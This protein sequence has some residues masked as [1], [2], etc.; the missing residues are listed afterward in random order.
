MFLLLC[1]LFASHQA[2]APRGEGDQ[3][4]AAPPAH[5]P[6]LLR[7]QGAHRLADRTQRGLRTRHGHQD[8]AETPRPEHHSSR[9]DTAVCVC[10]CVCVFHFL[11]LQGSLS[12]FLSRSL[13][14]SLDIFWER[15]MPQVSR[16]IWL[17]HV[18]LPGAQQTLTNRDKKSLYGA[19]SVLTHPSC[20]PSDLKM[21]RF[22]ETP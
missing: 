4:S 10:V 12:L 17:E 14:L 13:A 22:L 18:S 8:H 6:K 7:G 3:G 11:W 1:G 9:W 5:L 21:C 15:S 2:A 16:P 19:N 20:R